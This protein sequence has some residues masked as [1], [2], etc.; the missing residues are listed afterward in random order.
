MVVRVAGPPPADSSSPLEVRHDGRLIRAASAED[1]LGMIIDGY[2]DLARGPERT[3][4]RLTL[5]LRAREV[6]QALLNAGEVFE[7]STD[8]QRQVLLTDQ[9]ATPPGLDVWNAVVPLVLVTSFYRPLGDRD[10]PRVAGPGQIWW[11]DPETPTSLLETLHQVRWL[12]VLRM[13]TP[14][15]GSRY[16]NLG[17]NG[18]AGYWW[19]PRAAGV[20]A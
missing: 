11:I 10:Q 6:V 3:R 18:A 17:P 16:R 9:G 19:R 15:Q 5:A 12:D 8:E 2:A 4:A 14:D 1:A 7:Q 13:A 20:D